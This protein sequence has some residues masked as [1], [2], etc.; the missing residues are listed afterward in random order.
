M[1]GFFFYKFERERKSHLDLKAVCLDKQNN[2][3]Y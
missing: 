3:T 2:F 1:G